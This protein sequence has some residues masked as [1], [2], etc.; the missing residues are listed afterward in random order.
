VVTAEAGYLRRLADRVV[1]AALDSV[2]LRAALL[3]GSAARGN[4]D[5]FSDIDL[6]F[7]VD[8]VP[9]LDAL[10]QIRHAVGGV[11]PLRRHEPTEYATGEEFT[12]NG[13]RTEVSFTTVA[14]V[15]SQLSLLLDELEDVVSSRQKFLSGLAD[16][17]PLYGDELIGAWKTRLRNY[18]ES[19][20]KEMIERN[21]DFFPLWYYDEAMAARDSELWRLDILV[22]GAFNLL[23][24]LAGLNRVYFARFELKRTRDL[25]AKMPLAPP[26][27]ADRM[28]SLF[29]LPPS[30]AAEV[31]A[32]LVEETR[33]LVAAEFPDLS[34]PLPFPPGT[35][36]RPWSIREAN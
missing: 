22:S 9:S 13:V 25:V 20:R 5:R 1:R 6:L 27:L 26:S 4:A 8:D 3:A 17:L 33:A 10:S 2:P 31:F 21:W 15:E 18:P 29:R 12:L 23:G 30:E 36:Q 14:R 7:Y 16:G 19:L 11:N 28:E 24:V 32:A 34:L 35:Q